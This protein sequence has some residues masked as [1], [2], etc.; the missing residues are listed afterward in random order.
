M[1]CYIFKTNFPY[2]KKK[3]K[4]EQNCLSPSLKLFCAK[5]G[6]SGTKVAGTKHVKLPL[7]TFLILSSRILNCNVA[8]KTKSA[9]VE[10]SE[11]KMV[12]FI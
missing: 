8:E 6:K 10:A 4:K 2:G 7:N 1:I 3:A 12:Y 9:E 5:C 11:N